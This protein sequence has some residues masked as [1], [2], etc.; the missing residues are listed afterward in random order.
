[1]PHGLTLILECPPFT[2]PT[3]YTG[4]FT[5]KCLYM[6]IQYFILDA[7]HKHFYWFPVLKGTLAMLQLQPLLH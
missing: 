5:E 6:R 1:M 7:C 4:W 3:V 2:S